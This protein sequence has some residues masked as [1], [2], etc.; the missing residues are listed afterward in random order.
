MPSILFYVT[1]HLVIFLCGFKA[2]QVFIVTG[3]L[4]SR[5]YFEIHYTIICNIESFEAF[6]SY[7]DKTYAILPIPEVMKI[8]ID[9][10]DTATLVRFSSPY[11]IR[12]HDGSW[13]HFC[14][15]IMI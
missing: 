14:T 15:N 9:Q 11:K 6:P 4:Q 2:E 1:Q 12:P 5:F 10:N 13:Y 3:K 7:S 8:C